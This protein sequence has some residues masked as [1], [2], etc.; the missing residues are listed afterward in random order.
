MVWMAPERQYWIIEPLLDAGLGLDEISDLIVRLGFESV[1]AEGDGT[2]AALGDVVED[3]PAVV[4]A[5]WT[6]T[7]DRMLSAGPDAVR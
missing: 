4:R 5:A 7:L 1:V 2:L 6:R 3:H